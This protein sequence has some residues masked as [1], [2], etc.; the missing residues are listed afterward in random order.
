VKDC[1][2]DISRINKLVFRHTVFILNIA[3]ITATFGL[4]DGATRHIAYYRGRGDL[5]RVYST[6]VSSIK[7]TAVAGVVCGIVMYAAVGLV[8]DTIKRD[9]IYSDFLFIG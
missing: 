2:P 5:S 8:G 6:A 7:L 3:V 9:Q 4:Q 1:Y